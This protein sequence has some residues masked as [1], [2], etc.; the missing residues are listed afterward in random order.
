MDPY[1]WSAFL[2]T[3]CHRNAFDKKLHSY[4]FNS[5]RERKSSL[6]ID[7]LDLNSSFLPPDLCSLCSSIINIWTPTADLHSFQHPVIGTYLTKNCVPT[8]SIQRER[9]SSLFIDSLGLNS[10][11]YPLICVGLCCSNHQHINP[12]S[13][14]AFL[15]TS[16]HRNAFDKKLRS[17]HFN[18]ER[19]RKSSLFIDSLGLNSS[20]YPLICVVCAVQSSTYGPL[21]LI[22]I[23]SNILS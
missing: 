7:S 14:S 23:P 18:S 22:C 5:E 20:S 6:F 12:Y 13:W 8:T 2:P 15:P 9:I 17:Y 4:H 19:E 10:S 16:C 21:Q 1:S 3:S 11:S